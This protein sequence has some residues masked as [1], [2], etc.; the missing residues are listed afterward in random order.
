L[1]T[2]A[3]T[4]ELM[5]AVAAEMALGVE[6]AVEFWMAQIEEALDDTHLTTLGRLN[7]VAEILDKY[8][9]LTGKTHLEYRRTSA[10]GRV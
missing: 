2:A 10:V 3:I 8:K 1:A 5:N 6:T 7:A 9:R 4:T